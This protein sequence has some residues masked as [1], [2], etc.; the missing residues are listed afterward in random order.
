MTDIIEVRIGYD[1]IVFASPKDGPAFTAFT[2]SEIYQALAAQV[3]VDGKLVA[4]PYTK[5]SEINA[6]LP[7]ADILAFV[8]GTKHGTREVFETKVVEAGLQGHRRCRRD[9]GRH[10]RGQGLRDLRRPAHGRQVDRHRRRLHRD[11]RPPRQQQE[12]RRRV[13]SRLLREQHRQAQ[14]R[15]HVRRRAVDRVDRLRRVSGVASALLLH[16]E[17]AYRRDPR[18]QGIRDV[19]RLRRDRRSRMVR[20]PSTASSPTP[21]SPR[22]RRSSRPRRSWARACRSRH[23]LEGAATRRPF[24]LFTAGSR[25]CRC[26]CFSWSSCCLR[27]SATFWGG[28]GR[29]ALPAATSVSF[30]R[31]PTTMAGALPSPRR[32]R[33]WPFWSLWVDR[34]AHHHRQPG[35]VDDLRGRRS[36]RVRSI[37]S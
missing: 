20:S 4:N 32:C 35:V 11:P 36:P 15:D 9:Q 31:C 33:P 34:P 24:F 22:P 8:P 7:D 37:W 12:R 10:G 29:C 21:S 27:P 19:L 1:G 14:G 3:V 16:Q 5:W 6:D 26:P 17:G 30:T 28:S 2:P 23:R 25:S 18:P 13:R